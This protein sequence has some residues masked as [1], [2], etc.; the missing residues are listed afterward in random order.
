MGAELQCAFNTTIKNN[1]RMKELDLIVRTLQSG[2]LGSALGALAT[3]TRERFTEHD[4]LNH[5]CIAILARHNQLQRRRIAGT[6]GEGEAQI[7]ENQIRFATLELI[8]VLKDELAGYAAESYS[9]ELELSSTRRSRILFLAANPNGQPQLLLANE[10]KAIEAALERGRMRDRFE[11]RTCFAA[12]PEDF[13]QEILRYQPEFVHFAGHGDAEGI[14]MVDGQ[15]EEIQVSKEDLGRVFKLFSQVVACVVLNACHSATQS[16]AI[17]KHI[18][19]VI[20]SAKGIGDQA[21]TRFS[22]L[23]YTAIAEGQEIPFAFEFARLGLSL[24]GGEGEL[25]EMLP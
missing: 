11:I 10:V 3:F 23:F 4:E 15:N 7:T 19:H 25:Y 2:Q 12:S 8:G 9:E 22:A 21:A 16:A 20:G 5:H 17:R 18:P 24:H 14:Y 6:I 13:L 1:M